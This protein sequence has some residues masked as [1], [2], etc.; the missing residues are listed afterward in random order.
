MQ[1]RAYR[2]GRLTER[3]ARRPRDLARTSR[4]CGIHRKMQRRRWAIIRY[5]TS[6]DG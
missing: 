4:E 2:V 1:M 6:S 3:L 5:W